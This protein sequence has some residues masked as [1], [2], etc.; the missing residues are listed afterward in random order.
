V[1][2]VLFVV[3]L[4]SWRSGEYLPGLIAR[5]EV[6]DDMNEPIDNLIIEHLKALRNELRTAKNDIQSDLR[7]IKARLA[8]RE[9][10]QAGTDLDSNR[11]SNRSDEPDQRM[12]RIERRLELHDE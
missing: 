4:H 7:D 5:G 6:E 9:N 10:H 12:E 3:E 8:S 1:S 11:Q 2:F